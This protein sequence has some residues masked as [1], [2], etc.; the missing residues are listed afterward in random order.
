MFDLLAY[1]KHL[2]GKLTAACLVAAAGNSFLRW[3]SEVDTDLIM[4]RHS[5]T[6]PVAE[7]KLPVGSEEPPAQAKLS[8]KWR[9]V[10][11]LALMFHLLAVFFA[12]WNGAPP[13]SPFPQ[14]VAMPMQRYI[15][16][17]NL[18]RGNRFFA[19]DP[20]P[21]HII[22]YTLTMPD[23]S[24]KRGQLPDAKNHWPRLLYHR[25]FMLTEH[26]NANESEAARKQ[27]FKTY[28]GEILK[29]SGADTIEIEFV[30]H[31]IPPWDVYMNGTKL[32]DPESFRKLIGEKY[33]RQDFMDGGSP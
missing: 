20:G 18:N 6:R 24:E 11:S 4:S 26:L 5:K 10:I 16:V 14:T 15:G 8:A 1:T 32:D 23:G 3:R 22:R 19:P 25:Y 29:Q 13:F 7:R 27:M 31:G 28:A 9:A 12:V 33:Q 2:T 17:L 21:S 30:Q